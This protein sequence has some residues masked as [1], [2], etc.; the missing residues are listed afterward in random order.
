MDDVCCFQQNYTKKM[1][2][3]H[4]RI[5]GRSGSKRPVEKDLS[6]VKYKA[7]EVEDLVIKLAKE[8]NKPSMIGLILRDTYAIPSVK[9]V[10]GKSIGVILCNAK[11]ESKLPED[12]ESLVKRYQKLKKHLESNNK[13]LHNK[14]GL[15]L[16]ESKIRRLSSYYKQIGRV[17]SNWSV[18]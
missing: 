10:T 4:A 3:M 7:K 18:N 2:R 6:F 14:R 9:L 12:L 1:A 17:P 13:D 15:Q 5:R 8:D 16:I 11:M